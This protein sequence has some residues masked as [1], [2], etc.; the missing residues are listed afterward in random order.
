[1]GLTRVL[2]ANNPVVGLHDR[3]AF[4]VSEAKLPNR[5]LGTPAISAAAYTRLTPRYAE[6]SNMKLSDGRLFCLHATLSPSLVEA[7]LWG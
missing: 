4:G 7:P 3:A 1:M 2:V 5:A 6:M